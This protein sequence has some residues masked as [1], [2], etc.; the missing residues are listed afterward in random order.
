MQKADLHEKQVVLLT[1]EN[2]ELEQA[3]EMQLRELVFNIQR[4]Q[5]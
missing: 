3:L 1:R 5:R 2:C 4:Q